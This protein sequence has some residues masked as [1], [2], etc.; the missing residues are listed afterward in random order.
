MLDNTTSQILAVLN[1]HFSFPVS[2]EALTNQW[3]RI[4]EILRPQYDEIGGSCLNSGFLHADESGWRV[5]GRT[6]WLWRLA[7]PSETYFLIHPTRSEEA[8]NEFFKDY[9]NGVL[10]SDFYAMKADLIQ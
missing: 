9:F 1:Y 8:L 7:T 2:Q 6:Q 5:D 3:I 10:V 4:A